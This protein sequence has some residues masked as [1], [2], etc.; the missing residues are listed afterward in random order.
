M[1][2]SLL[3]IT[4][5]LGNNFVADEGVISTNIV[6]ELKDDAEA[7]LSEQKAKLLRQ[8][9]Q[10]VLSCWLNL[11]KDEK[12][13]R[14]DAGDDISKWYGVTVESNRIS[15]IDWSAS[16][17]RGTV[18]QDF[19]ELTAL[20]QLNLT[21]NPQLKGEVG[22]KL[23]DLRRKLGLSFRTTL[24]NE[25]PEGYVEAEREVEVAEKSQVEANK[26][27]SNVEQDQIEHEDEEHQEDE[28]DEEDVKK[29]FADHSEEVALV[30]KRIMKSIDGKIHS[31]KVSGFDP[32]AGT[33]L[34]KL[35]G[36]NKP[37][38]FGRDSLA[39]AIKLC[40]DAEYDPEK[41]AQILSGEAEDDEDDRGDEDE[42]E[43]EPI[44]HPGSTPQG[45]PHGCPRGSPAST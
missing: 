9:A 44:V 35:T 21:K 10:I 3:P 5:T 38:E 29:V 16:S 17:L 42:D 40:E 25:K 19:S 41:A 43:D 37:E 7:P 4:K 31:G 28:E 39:S 14:M 6:T 24:K 11:G 34:V 36:V 32:D 33:W 15:R 27:S 20:I 22:G 23:L 30:G 2:S 26:S 45:G 18:P 8:D 1:R 13:L 12:W